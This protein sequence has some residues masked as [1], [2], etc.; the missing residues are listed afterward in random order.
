M[1]KCTPIP[2]SCLNKIIPHYDF[3]E[4]HRITINAPPEKVYQAAKELTGRE[5]F[6]MRLLMSLRSLPSG[7]TFDINPD[8]PL[9]EVICDKGFTMLDDVMN[10]E[11]VFG[12]IGQFWKLK[13]DNEIM[14]EGRDGFISFSDRSYLKAAG[15][16]RVED[17]NGRTV[18]RTETR[19]AATSS[20]AKNKFRIYWFVIRLGSGF[21]RRMWLKAIKKRAELS[22]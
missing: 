17:L 5:I 9:L 19:V 22:A 13:D 2:E 14:I 15:N 6:L 12:S 16:M 18:L 11:V 21:I 1:M 7:K 20:D 4:V 3:H 8:L 10:S